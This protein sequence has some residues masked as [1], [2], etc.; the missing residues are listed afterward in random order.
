MFLIS[1]GGDP[2]HIVF[3]RHGRKSRK[4]SVDCVNMFLFFPRKMGKSNFSVQWLYLQVQTLKDT[5]HDKPIVSI[6]LVLKASANISDIKIWFIFGSG[7]VSLGFCGAFQFQKKN[8]VD[9]WV[10]MLSDCMLLSQHFC[11]FNQSG[12]FVSGL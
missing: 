1:N 8:W 3:V 9:T 5:F 7:F 2:N 6:V 4:I 12:S 11:F 10:P